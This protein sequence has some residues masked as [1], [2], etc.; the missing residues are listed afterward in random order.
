[1]L[2]TPFPALCRIVRPALPRMSNSSSSQAERLSLLR[3]LH[4]PHALPDASWGHVSFPV[5]PRLALAF[6]KGLFCGER[7]SR[8]TDTAVSFWIAETRPFSSFFSVGTFFAHH[9]DQTRVLL[10]VLRLRVLILLGFPFFGPLRCGAGNVTLG[11]NRQVSLFLQL[12]KHSLFLYFSGF[13]F[14]M[15][16]LFLSDLYS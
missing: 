12:G 1:M 3:Q 9:R 6:R 13:S 14:L 15:V 11:Q 8:G 2:Q 10:L 7:W 4:A 5:Y 16:A